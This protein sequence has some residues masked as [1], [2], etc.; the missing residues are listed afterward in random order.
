MKHNV[1]R[2]NAKTPLVAGFFVAARKNEGRIGH[3]VRV[4]GQRGGAKYLAHLHGR[5]R[6]RSSG[7]GTMQTSCFPNHRY[8]RRE[9][10]SYL[11][12]DMTS[13]TEGVQAVREAFPW[14]DEPMPNRW[15]DS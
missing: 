14:R 2:A 11:T 15:D 12:G 13:R 5:K 10:K 9:M 1:A 3:R 7:V 4:P 8:H 6:R